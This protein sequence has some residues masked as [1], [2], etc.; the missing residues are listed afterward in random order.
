M[1]GS[2][3]INRGLKIARKLLLDLTEM[4]L[5]AAGEFLGQLDFSNGSKG[6][7]FS[8]LA[9]CYLASIPRR[10]EFMGSYRCPNYR[11]SSTQRIGQCPFNER[12]LQKRNSESISPILITAVLVNGE[13]SWSS[14]TGPSISQLTLSKLLDQDIPSYQSRSRVCL[15]SSRLLGTTRHTSSW[16]EAVRD[17]ITQRSMLWPRVRNWR[18]L[19][20]VRGWWWALNRA[21][22]SSC[23]EE[24]WLSRLTVRT[25]TRRSSTKNKL[26]SDKIS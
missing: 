17:L 11:I 2:Y 19:G 4:G 16:E 7:R 1:N 25:E 21:W 10:P 9:R 3:Q 18:R 22:K 23:R 13:Y 14:R 6:R 15:L 26:R 12:R 8:W 5:P 24:S 20:W